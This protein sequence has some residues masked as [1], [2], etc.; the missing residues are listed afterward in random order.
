MLFTLCMMMVFSYVVVSARGWPLGSRLFP[1]F[2][3]ISMLVLTLIQSALELCQSARPE[4]PEEDQETGDLQVDWTIGTRLVVRRVSIIFGWLVGLFLGIWL[5]GFFIAVPLFVLLYLKFQG[6]EG[7]LLSFSLTLAAL[8][9][10][11]AV[12]DQILH[13]P[14]PHPLIAWPEAMLKFL[15]PWVY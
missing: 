8:L 1:W 10:L 12:F 9:F 6:R 4:S 3:G 15:L 14:W 2:V 7:W 13:V 5:F 11:I